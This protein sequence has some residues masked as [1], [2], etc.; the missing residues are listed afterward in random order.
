MKI[1]VQRADPAGNITLFVHSQVEKEKRAA[2]GAK[3]MAIRAFKAAQVGFLCEN[4]MEMAGGEFCGNA[5]RAYGMLLAKQK[6]LRGKCHL[7]LCVSGCDR[8]VGVDVD[9][10]AQTA[11]SEMPLPRFVRT[12]TVDGQHGTLVHLGGIA[13]L[14]VDGVEPTM[15]FFKKA[16]AAVFAS[17]PELEAY[18]VIF[19]DSTTHRMK[20]LVKALAVNTLVW[21]GSCGSGTLAAMVS[22]CEG[23]PDGEYTQEF[24]QP[25]GTVTATVIRKG[26]KI[27]NAYIGGGV[28]FDEPVEIEI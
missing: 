26:G 23:K 6:G 28:T 17:M 15:E 5:T 22:L 19:L 4:S 8:P 14:V 2:L 18:G 7:T 9:L 3:L 11:R 24:I 25:A 1:K 27:E 12:E 21:E 10:D 20:P 16:G 13:H